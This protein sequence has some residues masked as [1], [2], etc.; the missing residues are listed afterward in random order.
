[1]KK[2]IMKR[3]SWCFSW[4][5]KEGWFLQHKISESFLFLEFIL[6]HNDVI[7]WA[8][9]MNLSSLTT[10]LLSPTN[11]HGYERAHQNF[12]FTLTFSFTTI[13]KH[14]FKTSPSFTII[15]TSFSHTFWKLPFKSEA[16][17]N[18]AHLKNDHKNKI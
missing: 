2:F 6:T 11:L 1:M 9:E 14:S 15:F 4:I 5:I 12:S 3:D 17:C 18:L 8:L 10:S 16:K 13:F 7:L